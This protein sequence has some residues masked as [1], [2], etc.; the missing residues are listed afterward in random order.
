MMKAPITPEQLAVLAQNKFY[1]LT[2][3]E[4]EQRVMTRGGPAGDERDT[5]DAMSSADRIRHLAASRGWMYF[6]VRNTIKHRAQ[7]LAYQKVAQHMLSRPEGEM[8]A[9]DREL[10]PLIINSNEYI[11]WE[12]GQ[13]PNLW[14][15]LLDRKTTQ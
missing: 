12:R 14:E 3:S 8:G 2:A 13:V 1:E 6:E 11:G 4:I 9:V 10:V 5:L 15:V 7:K